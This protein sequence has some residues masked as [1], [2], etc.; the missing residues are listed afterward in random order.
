MQD[1]GAKCPICA[2]K[3]VGA[4]KDIPR[5]SMM[6]MPM[7]PISEENYDLVAALWCSSCV[8]SFEFLP[9]KPDAKERLLEKE[10]ERIAKVQ[11]EW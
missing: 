1:T 6:N 11:R 4:V 5:Y 7:G 2:G 10:R 9:D 8:V 3:I